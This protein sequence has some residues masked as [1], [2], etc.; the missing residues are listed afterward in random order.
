M[1][2]SNQPAFEAKQSFWTECAS[3]GTMGDEASFTLFVCGK[4]SLVGMVTMLFLVVF[5]LHNTL[6]IRRKERDLEEKLESTRVRQTIEGSRMY[7]P[8]SCV[9]Y[10]LAKFAAKSVYLQCFA[11]IFNF[12][13]SLYL[14]S[15]S[16]T[17]R[18]FFT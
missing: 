2:I 13:T 8:R 12:F 7:D 4:T 1:K 6:I 16:V 17:A 14:F 11:R 5:V 3:R 9:R 10:I 15:Y 18:N